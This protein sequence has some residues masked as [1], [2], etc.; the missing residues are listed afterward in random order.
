MET[1]RLTNKVVT[2]ET[3]RLLLRPLEWQDFDAYAK[4]AADADANRYL[5]GPQSR[6]VAWRGFMTMAG[7]WHLR[8]VSMFSVLLKETNEW[9]G[10]VGPW[11]PEGW[12]GTEVGWGISRAFWK[13]GFATEAA[14]ATI[15]WAFENLGWDD[16]VHTIDP[17]NHASIM[18]AQKLGASNRGRGRLPAPYENV[19]VDIWGQSR[20]QWAA[21]SG[22]PA[23]EQPA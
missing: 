10:R 11:Q 19:T 2:I 16:V 9:I 5:G 22:Q 18:V 6:P 7:A 21:H 4:N 1:K 15:D 20:E 17:R 8:G 12:P 23:S 3:P 14:A 13:Q